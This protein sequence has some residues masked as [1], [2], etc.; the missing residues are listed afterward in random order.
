VKDASSLMNTPSD[1]R[2][3]MSSYSGRILCHRSTLQL[4]M[5]GFKLSNIYKIC[6]FVPK[7]SYLFAILCLCPS[8]LFFLSYAIIYLNYLLKAK[9]FIVLILWM[10]MSMRNWELWWYY[11]SMEEIFNEIHYLRLG[12]IGKVLL[13]SYVQFWVLIDVMRRW[14]S[15][16]Y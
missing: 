13:Q 2:D 10:K 4:Y 9:Q 11:A 15:L 6:Y 7:K 8:L 14:R 1:T 12:T 5:Q 3:V 16:G